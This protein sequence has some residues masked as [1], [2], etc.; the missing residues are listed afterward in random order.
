MMLATAPPTKPSAWLQLIILTIPIAAAWAAWSLGR[1]GPVGYAAA[2]SVAPLAAVWNTQRRVIAAQLIAAS[3]LLAVPVVLADG[4][5]VLVVAWLCA[6]PTMWALAACCVYVLEAS[7]R[8]ARHLRALG[9]RDPLTGVANRRG[10]REA[11]DAALSGAGAP[12]T[13]VAVIALDLHGFKAINDR[14]GHDAGDDLLVAV[15]AAL[16][17]V[18][19]EDGTVARL[20][21]DEFCILAPGSSPARAQ[22]TA[23]L[24]QRSIAGIS[25][26]GATVST[27]AGLAMYPHDGDTLEALLEVADEALRATKTQA[28]RDASPV[29]EAGAAHAP[30]R[31]PV[32][33]VSRRELA[34]MPLIWRATGTMF[35]LY[36][37][38]GVVLAAAAPGRTDVPLALATALAA[39]AVAMLT[40]LTRP[41]PLGS[42]RSTAVVVATYVMAALALA[43][44]KGFD[45]ALLSAGIW[46]GPVVALRVPGR[47]APAA[48]LAVASVLLGALVVSGALPIVA[49]PGVLM[50]VVTLWGLGFV[51]TLVFE[52]AECHGK[53]LRALVYRDPLTGLANRRR[54][55][56]LIAQD[57]GRARSVIALDLN[58]FKALNDQV[59]HGAGDAL[60]VQIARTLRRLSVDAGEAI[61]LG[62]DE[63]IIDVRHGD[64]TA[65]ERIA[66]DIDVQLGALTIAGVRT[67]AAT[68]IAHGPADGATLEALLR[69][70]DQRLL[71]AKAGGTSL[72]LVG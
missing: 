28:R 41:A 52:A 6:C 67:S 30:R 22:V 16:T 1:L 3:I 36:A 20:G 70:A 62:G 39:L 50:A 21:G 31:G 17:G 68:G 58:G 14:I 53:Q 43:A 7:E 4:S 29:A 61:R 37:V 60:L 8:Q 69:A 23:A 57:D 19:G 42:L 45:G 24:A 48:H 55:D 40:V 56:Q 49:G 2:L 34:A 5:T 15:A 46:I 12:A 27:G 64:P 47:L 51:C 66:G 33:I 9:L 26:H 10:L 32:T 71:A 11:A 59:G 13:T 63:F 44:S 38:G 72:R 25:V 35:G 65:A 54:L 18:V